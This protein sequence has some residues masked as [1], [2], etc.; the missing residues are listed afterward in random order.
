MDENGAGAVVSG[1]MTL[2]TGIFTA[3]ELKPLSIL[4]VHSPASGNFNV[5]T[6]SPGALP[7]VTGDLREPPPAA[8]DVADTL[9]CKSESN[10]TPCWRTV[11]V[12]V[13]GFPATA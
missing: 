12:R 13:S 4:I 6:Y 7:R 2:R 11:N 10:V 8:V 3:L 1:A 9:G 5:V